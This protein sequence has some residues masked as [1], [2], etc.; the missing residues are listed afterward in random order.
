MQTAL[1][2]QY[3]VIYIAIYIIVNQYP[4]HQWWVHMLVQVIFIQYIHATAFVLQGHYDDMTSREVDVRAV[5][6]YSPTNSY[7]YITTSTDE[8]LVGH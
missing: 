5:R 2:I 4:D 6:C 7:I 1:L 8:P 3:L